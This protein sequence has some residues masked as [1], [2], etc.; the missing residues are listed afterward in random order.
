MCRIRDIGFGTQGFEFAA[1]CAGSQGL[2]ARNAGIDH[3]E[4][5]DSGQGVSDVD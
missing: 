5:E 4:S 2:L 1:D 3:M